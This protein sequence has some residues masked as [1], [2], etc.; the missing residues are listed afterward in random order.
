[1]KYSADYHSTGM[2]NHLLAALAKCKNAVQIEDAISAWR[3]SAINDDDRDHDLVDL[4]A[5]AMTDAI[6][7]IAER[8]KK[9]CAIRITKP[10]GTRLTFSWLAD[11]DRPAPDFN[12]AVMGAVKRALGGKGDD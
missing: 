6:R 12:Q 9:S 2:M 11:G 1:M 7:Q 5:D 8:R 3:D 4:V 10:D